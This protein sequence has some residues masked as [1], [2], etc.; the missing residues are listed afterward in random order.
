MTQYIKKI[1]KFI[2]DLLYYS[3]M[4]VGRFTKY[5]GTQRMLEMSDLLLT[6]DYKIQY[7]Q[8]SRS[9]QEFVSLLTIIKETLFYYYSHIKF[10]INRIDFII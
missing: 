3:C 8:I 2:L 10:Y 1:D 9:T 7:L 5:V 6:E 4:A